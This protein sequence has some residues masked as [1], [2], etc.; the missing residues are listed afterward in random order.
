MPKDVKPGS[1]ENPDRLFNDLGKEILDKYI[2]VGKDLG[3]SEN[4]LKNEL[5]SGMMRSMNDSL[6]AT[7]MLHLWQQSVPEEE[8]TYKELATALK[9]NKLVPSADKY[10]Y[11]PG[12]YS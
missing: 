6:K 5:N 12:I 2:S 8:F 1:I 9:K 7:K 11:T 10:C 3:L 4:D